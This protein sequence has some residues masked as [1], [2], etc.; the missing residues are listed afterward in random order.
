MSPQGPVDNDS[1]A[2]SGHPAMMPPLTVDVKMIQHNNLGATLDNTE[3]IGPWGISYSANLTPD[4]TGIGNWTEARFITCLHTGKWMGNPSARAILPP[5]PV[6]AYSHFTDG[7]LKAI[8]AYLKSIKP[9]HN[10]VPQA[11]PPVTH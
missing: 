2:L 4:S 5:M 11:E 9:I 8:F 7:E 6:D 1:L 3:W 10:V